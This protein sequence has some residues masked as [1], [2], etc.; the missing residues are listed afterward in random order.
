M[1]PQRAV[2]IHHLLNRCVKAGDELV[3]DDQNLGI[4]LFL[5]PPDDLLFL[6]LGTLIRLEICTIVM[7]GRNEDLVRGAVQLI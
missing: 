3:T 5:E 6:D 7:Y 4:I 2:Q 1:L